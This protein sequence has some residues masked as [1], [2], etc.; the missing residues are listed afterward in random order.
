M[1]PDFTSAFNKALSSEGFISNN[2]FDKGGFTYKGISRVK[3]PAWP[4]WKII[5]SILPS[6]ASVR[7]GT[8]GEVLNSNSTLQTLVIEFYRTE[9]WNKLQGD[10]LPS[11]LIA[12]ELFDISINLGVPVA[13][14][15]LQ[16]TINLLN[17]NV[18]LYP[19]I[20]VDGIIGS[21]T[22]SVLNKCISA[23]GE[24]LVFNLLNF[25][26]AK[27][28]IEIMERDHTQEIF[29][30]WFSRIAIIK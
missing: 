10:L 6:L 2:S 7:R 20:T 13:S 30:G 9:F 26:Q 4:G 21:Q 17:R 3:H 24:K 15:F 28:Y 1:K 19:D 18:N 29:I 23:N 16:K 22:L 8:V 14:E 25:Y 11:Q 5:D 27:R 12:D